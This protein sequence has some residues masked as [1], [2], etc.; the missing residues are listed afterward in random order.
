MANRR[1]NKIKNCFVF[2]SHK[3]DVY[4][5]R[6]MYFLQ[7]EVHGLMDFVILYDCATNEIKAS[8]YPNLI[9]Y[10]FNSKELKGFF[11]NN[12]KQLPNPL[13]AL[14]EMSKEMQYDHYLLM[15]NDVVFTGNFRALLKFV[16]RADCDYIHIATDDA[17]IPESHYPITLIHNNPFKRLYFSWSQFFYISHQLLKDAENFTKEND[18]FYYEFLLPTMAYNGDYSVRQFENF[19]CYFQLSWGPVQVYE[20]KYLRERAERTFYHP[21]KDLSIVDFL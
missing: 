3:I 21:I 10:F 7:Q 2:M 12:N 6:Y 16:G 19:G 11:Q 17:G 14:M 20:N 8:D 18:T 1:N 5:L 15:E 13:I 4:L 9:F